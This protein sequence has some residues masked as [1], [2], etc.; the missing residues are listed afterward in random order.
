MLF[1]CRADGGHKLPSLG[2]LA[3]N[4]VTM[5]AELFWF[6]VWHKQWCI[7]FKVYCGRGFSEKDASH[8]WL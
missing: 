4:L 3:H 1:V 8:L 6:T 7:Q 5:S 2:Y